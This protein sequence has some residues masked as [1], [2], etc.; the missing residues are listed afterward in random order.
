MG[1]N[2][3]AELLTLEPTGNGTSTSGSADYY[4]I[5][6]PL[7]GETQLK[8]K[9]LILKQ[10]YGFGGLLANA[11][12]AKDKSDPYTWKDYRKDLSSGTMT[13]AT[14]VG[15]ISLG[16]GVLVSS[17]ALA[18]ADTIASTAGALQFAYNTLKKRFK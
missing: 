14:A 1:S 12:R 6:E 10:G 3:H 4:A 17:P 2:A 18:T 15:A 11:N 5:N 9:P 13:A 7:P 8:I 16:A